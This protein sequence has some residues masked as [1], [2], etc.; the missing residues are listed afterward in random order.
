MEIISAVANPHTNEYQNRKIDGVQMRALNLKSLSLKQSLRATGIAKPASVLN[1][2]PCALRLE[3]GITLKVPSIVD[4]AVRDDRRME[5]TYGGKPYKATVV[6]IREPIIFPWITDVKKGEFDDVADGVGVYDAAV[7]KQIEIAYAFW[8]SYNFG[9]MDS[10]N[11]GGVVIWEGDRHALNSAT[12]NVPKFIN[13]ADSKREYYCEP[14]L[15]A[16]VL[17]EALDKQKLYYERMIQEAQTYFDDP[18]QRKNIHPMHRVWAQ[19]GLDQGWRE[20]APEWLLQI[21]DPTESCEGCGA[22]KK[23][24]LAHFCHACSRP[25]DP[26]R[27]FMEGELALDSVHMNRIKD[28]DWAKV[29]EE[30]AKRVRRRAPKSKGGDS[31]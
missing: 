11:M 19:Y 10:S 4:P 1:F 21:N 24:A 28:E 14:Q 27:S 12:I 2:N 5:F 18:D 8:Q 25:Y 31:K 29:H 16:D 30:E 22:G 23:R 20:K 3:G 17:A 9:A 15:F 13:L 6:T 7:C 26:F